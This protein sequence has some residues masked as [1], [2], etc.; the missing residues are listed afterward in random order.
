MDVYCA[1]CGTK[2][3]DEVVKSRHRTQEELQQPMCCTREEDILRRK[4][5]GIYKAMSEA[6]REGRQR[7]IPQSNRE[8]PR[9]KRQESGAK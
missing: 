9:R 2:I 5:D 1:Y 3:P 7:A 6:G 8:K 4:R